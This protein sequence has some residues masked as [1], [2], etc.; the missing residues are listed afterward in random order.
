MKASITQRGGRWSVRFDLP[1]GP[2]G[3][4]RQRRVS[5]KGGRRDAERVAASVVHEIDQGV[6]N[7]AKKLKLSSLLD[8]WLAECERTVQPNTFARYK[9][10]VEHHLRPHIGNLTIGQMD[11]RRV[12]WLISLW[13]SAPR[14]DGKPGKLSSKTLSQHFRTLSMVLDHGMRWSL[15]TSNPCRLVKPPRVEQR[16]M[17]SL[18]LS[19]VADFLR[20]LD[21]SEL[22][23]PSI[24]AIGTGM[25]RGELLGLQWQD[26]DFAKRLLHVRRSLEFV[27]GAPH[28]KGLKTK[29]S[30]RSIALPDFC[31]RAFYEQ[32][33]MQV[34]RF[35]LLGVEL[36]PESVVF[37]RL[38]QPWD[39][40]AFSLSFYRLTKRKLAKRL[41]FHDLRHSFASLLFN[42]GV[43]LKVVSEA[44]G[45]SDISTTGNIY[46]HLLAGLHRSAADALDQRLTQ[47]VASSHES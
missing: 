32:R 21:G 30:R 36:S 24:V 28:F 34:A 5:V 16:E 23:M 9:S 15:V 29:R 46:V 38:G 47:V 37:D 4:R 27:G 45:H 22:L 26:V 20:E 3:R 31:V 42:A 11:A 41:R 8:T 33:S 6:F 39:P 7:D 1:R 44:L 43:D 10:I 17:N 40:G 2:D 14:R 19:E 12:E 35:S 18:E 25:R 13:A